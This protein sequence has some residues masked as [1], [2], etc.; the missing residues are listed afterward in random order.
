MDH[1]AR[2][3]V[4]QVVVLDVEDG[5]GVG[6]QA[7]EVYGQRHHVRPCGFF[8]VLCFGIGLCLIIVLHGHHEKQPFQERVSKGKHD[9]TSERE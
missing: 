9:L 5:L 1:G 6:Q 7:R 3:E 4:G 8:F 2:I